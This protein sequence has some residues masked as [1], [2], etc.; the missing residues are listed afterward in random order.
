VNADVDKN[1]ECREYIAGSNKFQN[2]RF[3]SEFGHREPLNQ[4]SAQTITCSALPIAEE[5]VYIAF[6][7][8]GSA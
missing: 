3:P 7:D 1:V 2:N 6:D 4:E 5:Q 8:G